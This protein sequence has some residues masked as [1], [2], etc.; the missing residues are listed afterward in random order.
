MFVNANAG[1]YFLATSTSPAIGAGTP[2]YF[3]TSSFFGEITA[4]TT[5]Y[6]GAFPYIP[7]LTSTSD[8]YFN[9]WYGG[10]S[11]NA[12]EASYSVPDFWDL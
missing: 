1:A 11:Y 9:S 10:Y 8:S 4:S 5:P 7:T 2:S 6:I 12:P 3:P